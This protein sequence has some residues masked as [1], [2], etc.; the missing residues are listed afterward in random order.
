MRC[1]S[2]P[3]TQG[4]AVVSLLLPRSEYFRL[5]VPDGLRP[6]LAPSPPQGLVTCTCRSGSLCG[7]QTQACLCLAPQPT[8]SWGQTNISSHNLAWRRGAARSHRLWCHGWDAFPGA[9]RYSSSGVEPSFFLAPN[10]SLVIIA[11]TDWPSPWAHLLGSTYMPYACF[12]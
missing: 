10:F 2:T 12:P 5:F 1:R 9:H 7:K 8:S 11:N 3:S 6:Q 4:K